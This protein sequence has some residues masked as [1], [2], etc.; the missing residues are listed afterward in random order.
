MRW[1]TSVGSLARDADMGQQQSSYSVTPIY[2]TR[3]LGWD[4]L[5][6]P[7]GGRGKY[8][9]TK[10]VALALQRQ[11]YCPNMTALVTL[12]S[13]VRGIICAYLTALDLLRLGRYVT[14]P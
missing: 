7:L 13:P 5:A 2:W 4:W 3:L 14:P 8:R 10:A 1:S 11:N 6:P 9:N 12:P